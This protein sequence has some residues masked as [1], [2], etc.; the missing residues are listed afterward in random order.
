[1]LKYLNQ[2]IFILLL[3]ANFSNG[4]ASSSTYH[5]PKKYPA[6]IQNKKWRTVVTLGAGV[7][8]T[9]S[10]GTS[11]NFPI[12]DPMTDEF[13]SYTA[14]QPAQSS[15]ELEAFVGAQWQLNAK[16][17][18]QQGLAYLAPSSFSAAGTLLQ[19]ADL[20]SADTY[21]YSY[22][23]IVRDILYETKL[24]YTIGKRFHPYA[25]LGLGTSLN[26]SYNFQTTVPPT[27]TFTREYKC[28]TY[29]FFSYAV[30]G[31][32]AV[33]LNDNMR[34]GVGYRFVDFGKSQFGKVTVNT[35]DVPG[36]ITQSHL[37]NNQ[38]FTQLSWLF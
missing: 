32:L 11:Q 31:G 35:S 3:L 24:F 2:F 21:N 30:G 19:G 38:A 34:L 7:A 17:Q 23:I 33:D 6:Y 37:Y 1:M 28:N 18:L 26:T 25:E 12:R 8:T 20:I 36:T 22:K 16:W 27:I 9:K 15:R 5:L 29:V 13:Y 10:V 4:F 14:N